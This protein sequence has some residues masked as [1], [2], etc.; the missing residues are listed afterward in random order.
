MQNSIVYASL[1][2]GARSESGTKPPPP[3]PSDARPTPSSPQPQQPS[4]PSGPEVEDM[5]HYT[6]IQGNV[7][8]DL[9]YSHQGSSGSDDVKIT[10]AIQDIRVLLIK[11]GKIVKEK[12]TDPSGNYSF[13]PD[14]RN[15]FSRNLVWRY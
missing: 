5:Y 14:P 13:S 7:F 4:E 1:V 15:L 8:E 2:D 3:T 6:T 12:R 9:G 11:D 10:R